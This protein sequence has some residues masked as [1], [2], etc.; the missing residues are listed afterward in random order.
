MFLWPEALVVQPDSNIG[1]FRIRRGFWGPLLFIIR[2]PQH[3]T[4]NCLGPCSSKTVRAGRQRFQ[5][6]NP[7]YRGTL[8]MLQLLQ[9]P[10]P[11]SLHWWIAKEPDQETLAP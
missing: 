9:E 8:P 3:S 4:G 10:N 1:A 5:M 2:N 11:H 6:A 7:L